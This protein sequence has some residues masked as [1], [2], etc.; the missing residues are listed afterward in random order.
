MLIRKGVKNRHYGNWRDRRFCLRQME[1]LDGDVRGL[2]ANLR[3]AQLEE[4]DA[5]V[6]QREVV[7]Q[8]ATRLD[9]VAYLHSHK[10]ANLDIKTWN[11]L[12]SWAFNAHIRFCELSPELAAR[13]GHSY[14]L[15]GIDIWA[16]AI[17][18][19]KVIFTTF[20]WKRATDSDLLFS[21]LG[22]GFAIT[23]LRSAKMSIAFRIALSG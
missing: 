19:F 14:E 12:Y 20:L 15:F 6:A 16:L 4:A 2:L 1:K 5:V 9:G 13:Q 17:V 18:L 7:A 8:S 10:I 21:I 22:L 3:E 23:S 11:C